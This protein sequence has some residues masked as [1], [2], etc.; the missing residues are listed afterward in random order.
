MLV[1]SN[2][3]LS[4]DLPK[5]RNYIGLACTGHDNAIAIVNSFGE[6]VFAEAIER[7]FQY[8]RALWLAGEPSFE[9]NRIIEKYC[10]PESDLVLAKTWSPSATDSFDKKYLSLS[11][12]VQGIQQNMAELQD[13][14]IFELNAARKNQFII[15]QV[16][17][18]IRNAG[19]SILTNYSPTLNGLR[20]REVI[21]RGY[22]HHLTHAM[23]SFYSSGLDEATCMITDGFGESASYKFYYF[24]KDG[25]IQNLSEATK[26]DTRQASLGFFYMAICRACG[27]NDAAGEEWK[28]MGLAPY[29]KRNEKI[30]ELLKEIIQV[31]GLNLIRPQRAIEAQVELLKNWGRKIDAPAIECAD[32][33][34]T[35][36]L[37]FCEISEK[38][39]CNL[40]DLN[41]SQKLI[42]GGGCGLNSSWNGK[43]LERTKFKTLFCPSAPADDGNAIG[44]AILAYQDDHSKSIG[45]QTSSSGRFQ[46]PYLGSLIEDSEIE[47]TIRYCGMPSSKLSNREVAQKAAELL[48]SGKI[49]GW[50]QGRAE[51]GPRALGHRSILADPR[52][53]EMKDKINTMVKF[54][55]EFRPFAPSILHEYGNEY[56][57]NYQE[58]PYMERTLVFR[59]A[60]RHLVPAVVHVDGTGRLQTVKKEWDEMYFNLISSFHQLTGVPLILNTSYNVMGKPISHSIEDVMAVFVTSGLDAVVIGNYII[61]KR[62]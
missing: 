39:L 56:F 42:I 40:Y 4:N 46:S 16:S 43:I 10:D 15:S 32:L 51:F 8:K 5:K 50:I 37:Y 41:L 35:G 34:F 53:P 33:A 29:G 48:A 12:R 31:E 45:W 19:S 27:F 58:S 2:A 62:Q 57:E 52:S 26:N 25:R 47:R 61:E 44:A 60:I 14:E 17:N 38:L 11:S 28:V 23:N 3:C 24:N 21:L 54:R 6:L 36:Q 30:Y 59:K 7:H 9:F 13:V 20:K 55:E 22:D 1:N 18:A 49:I